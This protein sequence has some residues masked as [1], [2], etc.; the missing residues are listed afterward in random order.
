MTKRTRNILFYSALAIFVLLSAVILILAL[1]YR[2]D[3]IQN[4]LVKTS[5]LRIK[6]SVEAEVYINEQLAGGTSF[7]SK[8]F[9]KNFMLPRTYTVRVQKNNYFSWQKSI[10]TKAGLFADFSGIV[11]LPKNLP[12]EIVAFASFE[13]E[14]ILSAGRTSSGIKSHD[15][16]KSLTFNSHEIWVEW[17]KD[18]NS[19]PF[20]KSG[21]KELIAR[22]SQ[23]VWGVQWHKN[24]DHLFIN[25]GGILKFAEIDTRGSVNIF[26]LAT[27]GKQFY[28]D[29]NADAV[30][31]IEGGKVIKIPLG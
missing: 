20:R 5:S 10:E 7:L 13:K 1:G 8:T 24:S 14:K 12:E 3:F 29:K 11:L 31:K 17:L 9:V 15:G 19:Q 30:Y 4:K 21:D 28:Y 2:Y 23:P 6:T 22:F 26:D 25:I 27:V 16:L 18:T